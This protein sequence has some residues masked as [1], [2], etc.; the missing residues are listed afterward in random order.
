[1]KE[2]QRK[3]LKKAIHKAQKLIVIADALSLITTLAGK[4]IDAV[5]TNPDWG[6]PMWIPVSRRR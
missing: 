6:K 3:K 4:S 1:M 2:K 5:I